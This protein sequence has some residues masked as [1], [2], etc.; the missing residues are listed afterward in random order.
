M[1]LDDKTVR[2]IAELLAEKRQRERQ[3]EA[4]TRYTKVKDVLLYIAVFGTIILAPGAAVIFKPL[5]NHSPKYISWK[6]F[7]FHYL[8]QTL[9]RLENQHL[10]DIKNS[11]EGKLVELTDEG[12]KK[13]LRQGLEELEIKKPQNWDRCWRILMYDIANKKKNLQISLRE[14][15]L[16]LGFISFQESVY[17]YP[18]PCQKEVEMIKNYYGLTH[19]I[20]L[21]TAKEIENE[22]TYK[23]YFNLTS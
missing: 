23:T 17:I 15:I 6:A 13:I 7:N 16:R 8:R 14:T 4:N 2:T 5:L 21:I 18:Y 9:R 12:R 22:E 1:S 20:K 11:K 19:E 10:I 3:E